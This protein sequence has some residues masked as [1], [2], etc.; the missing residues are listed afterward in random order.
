MSLHEAGRPSASA[1]GAL[2][3]NCL[4]DIGYSSHVFLLPTRCLRP[5]INIFIANPS[6]LSIVLPILP[7]FPSL[8]RPF[9]YC[10][11]SPNFPLT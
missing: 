7:P 2:R 9:V 3:C 8:Q 4:F 1:S 5:F 6:A 11:T 10:S